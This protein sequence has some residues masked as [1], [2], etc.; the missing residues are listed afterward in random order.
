MVYHAD[1]MI[2]S[3]VRE[4]LRGPVN[5]V[6]VCQDLRSSSRAC[7]LLLAVH[8]RETAKRLLMVLQDSERGSGEEKPFL[9]MFTENELLCLLFPYRPDRRLDRFAQ[10]Q[11]VTPQSRERV[12]V[13]LV[14]ECLSVPLPYPL[15][16]LALEK[17]N[18]HLL[19]DDGVY[20]TY[21]FDLSRMEESVGEADC[22]DRCVQI[23]LSLLKKHSRRQLKSFELLRKKSERGAYENLPEL[24][25]D[26][27]I[28]ALPEHKEPIRERLHGFWQRNR[29]TFFR[30]L[31]RISVT[32]AV[33]AL[34]ILICQLIFGN[35][36]LLRI[37]QNTFEVIG[38]ENLTMK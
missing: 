11:L 2:L 21:S 8:D 5:D 13:N 7:Y 29:D 1:D 26:I 17:E 18:V 31:L 19:Q 6:L 32:A 33:L 3:P 37:F 16:Y 9:K 34:I 23:L 12:C 4:I 25:R 36:P 10:G 27:R 30:I 15:L 14:M 38:T 35:F 28:S 20:F 24:Y 22:T